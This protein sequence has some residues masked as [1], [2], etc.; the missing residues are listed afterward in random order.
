LRRQ[1]VAAVRRFRQVERVTLL[2][3]QMGYGF[4]GGG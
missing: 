2:N 1:A 4:L 3:P